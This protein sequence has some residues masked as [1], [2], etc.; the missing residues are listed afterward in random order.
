MKARRLQ[1]PDLEVTLT[2]DEARKVAHAL[3][4]TTEAPVNSDALTELRR[5]IYPLVMFTD[6]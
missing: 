3:G 6:A 5:L 2:W 1:M 4:S